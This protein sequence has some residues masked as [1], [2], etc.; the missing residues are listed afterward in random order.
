[1]GIFTK[2]AVGILPQDYWLQNTGNELLLTKP[3]KHLVVQEKETKSDKILVFLVDDDRAVTHALK[4]AILT[5]LNKRVEVRVFSTGEECMLNMNQQPLIAILD[6]Y[7]DSNHHDAMNGM[8]VLK[9]IKQ[10]SPKT[11]VIMLSGQS[12]IDIA[13][14]AIKY[15]AFDYV[16]K[17]EEAFQKISDIIQKIIQGTDTEKEVQKDLWNYRFV[18]IGILVLLIVFFYLLRFL[19]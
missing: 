12:N 5:S 13:L 16:S 17:N 4:H 14:N 11:N 19:A 8:K 2:S 3:D 15:K 9:K 7:L 10:L 6:Y 1:M 18:N